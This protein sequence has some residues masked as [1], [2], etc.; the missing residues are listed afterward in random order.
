MGHKNNSNGKLIVG[1]VIA[2]LI[3]M[4]AVLNAKPAEISFGFA[5]VHISQAI[6]ILVSMTLGALLM[7][8]MGFVNSMKRRNKE[9]EDM[10]RVQNS[11]EPSESKGDKGL[12][13]SGIY[14][15]PPSSDNVYASD[16]H[17]KE[18]SSS[19]KS[20]FK[21]KARS[22]LEPKDGN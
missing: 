19:D 1:L 12:S 13:G 22:F 6:V 3:T 11:N 2:V 17:E 5:S 21:D 10:Q 14:V 7:Y 9:K 20:G 15:E 8:I 4:F 18:K 16:A